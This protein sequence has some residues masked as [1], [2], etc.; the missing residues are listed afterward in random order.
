MRAFRKT[1]CL[2]GRHVRPGLERLEDRTVPTTINVDPSN[3]L[4]LVKTARPGD[5]VLFAAG[6][7][8]SGLNLS[9][10][11]GTA[12]API[13]F[14]GSAGAVIQGTRGANTVELDSTAYLVFQNFLV[15]SLHYNDGIKA[16]GGLTNVSHDVWI[17]NNTIVNADAD[18]Q[19]VGIS[20]KCIAWNWV[21]YGNTVDGAGTGL[22]LGDSSGKAPFINGLIESNL[23]QHCIGYGGQVKDQ[24]PYSLVPGMPDGP[25]TTIVRYNTFFDNNLQGRG[26]QGARPSLFTGGLP[27]SGPGAS[28]TYQIY[29][30]VFNRNASEALLQVTSRASIHD[31]VFSDNSQFYAIRVQPHRSD[32]GYQFNPDH[33]AIYHNTIYSAPTGISVSGATAAQ[34]AIVGNLIFAGVAVRGIT[35]SGSNI[36]DTVACAGLYVANPS[37]ALDQMDFTPLPGQCQGPAVDLS[38]F[39]GDVDYN[40]DFNGN[41]RPDSDT[42]YGAILGS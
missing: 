5:T 30:N 23:V 19:T 34:V 40:L 24:N 17:L 16:G 1:E 32:G 39:A 9:R 15:D 36:T 35:P 14:D 21:I 38:A 22:Y 33:V 41:T 18:Q 42:T 8:P 4:S 2:S 31:N 12:D 11:S 25:N 13:T 7:Y 20:T 29:G 26:G 27:A 10:M 6:N 28:D 3:Y 37:T